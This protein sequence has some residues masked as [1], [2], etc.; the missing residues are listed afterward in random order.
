MQI[1]KDRVVEKGE[2]QE[3]EGERKTLQC[4]IQPRIVLRQHNRS[5][6]KYNKSNAVKMVAAV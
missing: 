1:E 4:F 3:E 6:L 5:K 2:E